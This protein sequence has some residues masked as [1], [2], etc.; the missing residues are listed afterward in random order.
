MSQVTMLAFRWWAGQH[1]Q[2]GQPYRTELGNECGSATDS[3]PVNSSTTSV[4]APA[5][6]SHC[7]MAAP[8]DCL[9]S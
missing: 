4:T 6:S 2:R 5:S 3:V 8:K 1:C 7:P 9:R